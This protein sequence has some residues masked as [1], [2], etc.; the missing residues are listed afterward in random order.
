VDLTLYHGSLVHGS[1]PYANGTL[2]WLHKSVG[3]R[4]QRISRK[5][6]EEVGVLIAAVLNTI[7]YVVQMTLHGYQ[8]GNSPWKVVMFTLKSWNADN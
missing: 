6:A 5:V 7:Q 2:P 8:R 4:C 1:G 3:N